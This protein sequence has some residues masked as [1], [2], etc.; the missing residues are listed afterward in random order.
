MAEKTVKN[1]WPDWEGEAREG[2]S[3]WNNTTRYLENNGLNCVLR[4]YETHREERKVAFEHEILM[5]LASLPLSFQVP[6]PVRTPEGTTIIRMEDGSGRLACLFEYIEGVSPKPGEFRAARSFGLAAAE[7][8]QA[9]AQ[10]HPSLDPVYPPYYEIRSAYPL[11]TPETVKQFCQ[12]PPEPFAD[13]T[14]QLK[15][16][17]EACMEVYER[18]DELEQLPRQLIHGDLNPSN[19]LVLEDHPQEVCALLDFEFCTQDLRVMEPAVILSDLIGSGRKEIAEQFCEGFGSSLRLTS[20]EIAVI[21]LLLRLRKVDV[22]LHFMSR[23]L[24]GTDG[25]EVLRAQIAAQAAG[26]RELRMDTLWIRDLLRDH[27][28]DHLN[29]E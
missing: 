28:Q 26:L 22:F 12:Q 23:F 27:L 4:I 8:S 6:S 15:L 5:Q 13:L 21:P 14:D 9:L 17:Q 1:F 16:L 29:R 7:L 19:L 25:P 2:A 3:G 18:L 20:K 24:N 11:C 10:I